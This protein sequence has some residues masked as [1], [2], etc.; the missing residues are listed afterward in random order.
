MES[1]GL[2]VNGVF[3]SEGGGKRLGRNFTGG[4]A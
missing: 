3:D 4:K 1:P 2:F